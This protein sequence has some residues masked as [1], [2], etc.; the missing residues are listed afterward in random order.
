MRRILIFLLSFPLLFGCQQPAPPT[1]STLPA[2]P[3]PWRQQPFSAN[4]A[5]V[6]GMVVDFLGAVFSHNDAKARSYLTPEYNTRVT[7][8]RQAVGIEQPPETY[9]IISSEFTGGRVRFDAELRYADRTRI[10]VVYV[11]YQGNRGQIAE[12]E[13]IR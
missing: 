11:D 7:D 10:V 9:S 3:G 8:L 1:P 13:P 5:Q 2:T 6:Y 4:E 12:I